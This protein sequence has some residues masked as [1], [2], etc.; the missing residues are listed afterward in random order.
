MRREDV[1]QVEL[2]MRQA[3][4]MMRDARVREEQVHAKE[5]IGNFVTDY[6]LAIQRFLFG[7]L[8]EVVPG[9]TF[10]GEEE[11]EGN[12]RALTEK[13]WFVD[14]IDGTTN[15]LFDYR[16]SCVSVGLAEHG[17]MTAGFVYDP[18]LDEFYMGLA[19]EGSWRNNRALRIADRELSDGIVAFGCAGSENDAHVLFRALYQ[20][21]SQVMAI[22]NVGSAALALCRIATGAN[23][24]YL[25]MR[26]N[27]YDYAAASVILREAGG[28]IGT[29]QGKPVPLDASDSVVAG[30][31]SAV[32]RLRILVETCRKDLS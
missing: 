25:Q 5:G 31:P 8:R 12:R 9:A 18:Y 11:T 26:L 6:D 24:A 3:G 27:P 16:H 22:R 14:P 2:A 19:G 1:A 7:A 32:R 20:L 13:T 28:E 15:F 10:F 4:R 29:L 17:E 21:Y 23:V 30:T